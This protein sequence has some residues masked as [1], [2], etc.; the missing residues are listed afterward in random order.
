M[1]RNFLFAVISLCAAQMFQEFHPSGGVCASASR[2]PTIVTAAF[3]LSP[4]GP[5]T[6]IATSVRPRE[7]Q[8]GERFFHARILAEL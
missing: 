8:R 5:F 1:L 3:A 6:V 2:P 4:F 7:H